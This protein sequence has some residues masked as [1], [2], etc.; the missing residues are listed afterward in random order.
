ME[1]R[2]RRGIFS[3][4]VLKIEPVGFPN[5]LTAK[6]KEQ[7]ACLQDLPNGDFPGGPVAKTP[8][9]QCKG[10]GLHPWSGN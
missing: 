8:R 2:G 7:S 6:Q 10:R 3:G 9:F 4:Y 5:G 1:E